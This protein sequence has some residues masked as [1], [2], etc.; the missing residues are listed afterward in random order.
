MRHPASI[1]LGAM[2]RLMSVLCCE[3]SDL[4]LSISA[5]LRSPRGPTRMQTIKMLKMAAADTI[6]VS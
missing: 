2:A 5:L 3:G 4:E 1:V 6:T